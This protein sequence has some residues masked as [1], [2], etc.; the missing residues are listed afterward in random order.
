MGNI[1]LKIYYACILF[2][3]ILEYRHY[4]EERVN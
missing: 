2:F 1:N 4:G 3:R